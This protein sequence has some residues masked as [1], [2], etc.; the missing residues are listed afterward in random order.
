MLPIAIIQ[1]VR[2]STNSIGLLSRE[3]RNMEPGQIN[4]MSLFAQKP[5]VKA[6]VGPTNARALLHRIVFNHS[7]MI[8][9]LD[10]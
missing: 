3:R 2:I 4:K 6:R 8:E 9:I 10:A 5:A 1:I 7:D